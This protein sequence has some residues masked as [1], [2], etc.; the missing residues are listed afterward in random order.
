MENYDYNY[1]L[2]LDT[3]DEHDLSEIYDDLDTN[4]ETE[5][6]VSYAADGGDPVE[7]A[8]ATLASASISRDGD[9][10]TATLPEVT[11][12]Q[13]PG[14]DINRIRFEKKLTCNVSISG[15]KIDISNIEGLK[16]DPGALAPWMNI[17]RIQI[18]G[19][20]ATVTAGR[21]GV[22][23]DINIDLADGSFNQIRDT[24]RRANILP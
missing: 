3:D 1:D 24:L 8:L 9:K 19:N 18:E 6:Y 2:N 10:V 22:Y 5:Q 16:A 21:F 7:L 4:E 20:R 15:Q 13:T 11:D 23:T 17:T 12:I 14:Q